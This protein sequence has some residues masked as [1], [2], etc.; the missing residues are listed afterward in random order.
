MSKT[1]KE[2]PEHT[3]FRE[4]LAQ[5]IETCDNG[6][7]AATLPV[8]DSLHVEGLKGILNTIKKLALEGQP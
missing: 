6:L 7:A 3:D 2:H 8:P 1:N 5:I 4:R